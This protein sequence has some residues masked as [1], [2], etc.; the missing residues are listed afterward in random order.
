MSEQYKLL[1]SDFIKGRR[2]DT[3][4]CECGNIF[5]ARHDA[6][7]A[8]H[9]LSCGCI[10]KQRLAKMR[11]GKPPAI[12]R[13][14]EAKKPVSSEYNAWNHMKTRCF[15]PNTPDWKDYGGRGIKIYSAWMVFENFLADMGRKPVG[16]YSLDRINVNGNYEPGNC[17]WATDKEQA[18]NKRK[19]KTLFYMN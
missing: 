19:Y 1:S 13:H 18:N 5:K 17:R 11:L 16:K 10:R 15:N 3:C 9:I 7:R 2:Y 12:K 14:G 8:F 4:L 6:L